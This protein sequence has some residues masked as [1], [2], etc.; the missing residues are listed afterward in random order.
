MVTNQQYSC[1]T[2]WTINEFNANNKQ[3]VIRKF[4]N[5]AIYV[6]KEIPNMRPQRKT[7]P[8]AVLDQFDDD[9]SS[10]RSS[11]TLVASHHPHNI[12]KSSTLTE[13][14]RFSNKTPES[15]YRTMEQSSNSSNEQSESSFHSGAT[16]KDF[17][18]QPI[19]R[20]N[21]ELR[22]SLSCLNTNR[23]C[24]LDPKEK[25]EI[26]QSWIAKKELETRRKALQVAKLN[27]LKE[28]E[29]LGLI[30]KER[31]NFRN[32]L[33]EK[34]KEEEKKRME[35]EL[36]AEE[37]RL[38][39]IEK[40]K[41]KVESDISYNMWLRRKKK[42]DLEKR[43]SE[44]LTLLQTYAEKQKRMEE[45]EMAYQEWLEGSKNR[46]KPI[47]MN[48]GLQS[49]RSSASVT[50]INPVPW[51]PNIDPNFKPVSHLTNI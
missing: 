2:S 35:K 28:E 17:K 26:V 27:K 30:E 11:G 12:I 5:S 9:G 4:I 32:W 21:S 15:G 7:S 47:P 37:L 41:K 18:S 42:S 29:R 13:N 43:I 23:T 36:A 45:N 22:L 20:P 51:A 40:D 44:K 50:Y 49:L 16:V 31:E 38:K 14:G 10:T 24:T 8:L 6:E 33:S 19:Q 25:E 3:R 1:G 48:R 39:Q 34:K 46:Q